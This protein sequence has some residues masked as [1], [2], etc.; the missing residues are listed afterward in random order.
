MRSYWE[1]IIF[2]EDIYEHVLVPC[3]C[4]RVVGDPSLHP[5]AKEERRW[6]MLFL[7]NFFL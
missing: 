5:E 2:M 4:K 6:C 1:L 3:N 7:C